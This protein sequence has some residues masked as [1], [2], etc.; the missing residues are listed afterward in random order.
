MTWTGTTTFCNPI[1]LKPNCAVVNSTVPVGFSYASSDGFDMTPISGGVQLSTGTDVVRIPVR[2]GGSRMIMVVQYKGFMY[3]GTINYPTI[4]LRHP[5]STDNVAWQTKY[6]GTSTMNSGWDLITTTASFGLATTNN[7]M[8]AA[9]G[10][11]DTARYGHTFLTATS[12]GLAQGQ[13]YLECM[14]SLSTGMATASN[15]TSVC[16]TNSTTLMFNSASLVVY[17]IQ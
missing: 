5:S 12:A 1:L 15:S 10:P 14:F 4:C 11:F 8:M 13:T 3:P 7:V 9:F 16:V 2:H 17:E 6:G